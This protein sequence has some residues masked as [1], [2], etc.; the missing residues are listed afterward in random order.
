MVGLAESRVGCAVRTFLV[1]DVVRMAHPTTVYIKYI[2]SEEAY[3]SRSLSK[4][5]NG[6]SL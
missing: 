6:F 2:Y 1:G 3:T 4:K 5:L